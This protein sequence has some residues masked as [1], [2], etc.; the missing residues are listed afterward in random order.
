MDT[1]SLPMWLRNLIDRRSSKQGEPDQPMQDFSGGDDEAWPHIALP[2]GTKLVFVAGV[3]GSDPNLQPGQTVAVLQIDRSDVPVLVGYN[4][5]HN[6]QVRRGA[7]LIEG[8]RFGLKVGS[9][10]VNFFVLPEEQNVE[11]IG[12][13]LVEVTRYDDPKYPDLVVF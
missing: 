5:G 13:S 11:P 2:S 3:D 9:E 12:I 10:D 8:G 7:E 6:V 1:S 4:N